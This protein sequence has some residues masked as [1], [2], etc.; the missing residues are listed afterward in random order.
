MGE[1]RGTG[2]FGR[3]RGDFFGHGGYVHYF[4]LGNGFTNVYLCQEFSKFT[5]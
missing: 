2:V 5:L 3:G 4:G 1:Q